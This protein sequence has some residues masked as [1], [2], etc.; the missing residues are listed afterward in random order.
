LK[1]AQ[2]LTA[3]EDDLRGELKEAPEGLNGASHK[4]EESRDY[5]EAPVHGLEQSIEESRHSDIT[6]WGDKAGCQA[7]SE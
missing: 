2:V 7:Q 3:T 1:C 4:A 5:R 6:R